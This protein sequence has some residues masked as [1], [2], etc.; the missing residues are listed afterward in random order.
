MWFEAPQYRSRVGRAQTP[1]CLAE[2]C[3]AGDDPEHRIV[4][5]WCRQQLSSGD[6]ASLAG[7]R[8]A[9]LL[10]L[11]CGFSHAY[12]SVSPYAGAIGGISTLSAD[13]GAQRTA[14]G[15]NLSSYSPANGGALN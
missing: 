3:R 12:A 8:R 10:I 15:L 4:K 1:A 9:R 14:Q 5:S 13:A 6:V 11:L 7:M 2:N